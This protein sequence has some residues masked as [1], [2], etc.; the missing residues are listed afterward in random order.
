MKVIARDLAARY[1]VGEVKYPAFFPTVYGRDRPSTEGVVVNVYRI[2]TDRESR[3]IVKKSVGEYLDYGGFVLPESGWRQIDKYGDDDVANEDLVEIQAKMEFP[4]VAPLPSAKPDDA[5]IN[6]E[7]ARSI[8]DKPLFLEIPPSW[9][10]KEVFAFV[11][12]TKGWAWGYGTRAGRSEFIELLVKTVPRSKRVVVFGIHHPAVIPVIVSLG[13]DVVTSGAHGRYA[14]K[15]LYITE[16]SIRP[17]GELKELPCGCKICDGRTPEDLGTKG[18]L[19]AEHNLISFVEEVKKTRNAIVEGRLYEY[20]KRR[21]LTHPQIYKD[22]KKV[23]ASEWITENLPFPKQS[24]IYLFEKE[25]RPEIELGRSLAKKR[26][27]RLEGLAYTYPF[28]QVYPPIVEARPSPELVVRSVIKYQYGVDVNTSQLRWETRKG[29]PRKIYMGDKY[30]GL[31]R[32]GDGFFVPSIEGAKWLKEMAPPPAFRIVLDS[33]GVEA[34]RLKRS[35]LT[36]HVLDVDPDL[37]PNM[38]VIVTD[39]DDEVVAT[40][41]SVL[42]AREVAEIPRT[43]AVK[44]RHR[45][46]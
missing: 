2:W 30:L 27:V 14:D 29:I 8:T 9:T 46:V 21:S 23:V 39:E 43:V 42:T 24:S 33:E 45:A 1:F 4:V 7:V 12:A 35:P 3:K 31:I 20:A 38:E 18:D 17:L 41:R 19:L 5:I 10:E 44:I 37:R 11:E 26:G 22:F 25:C 6:A 16:S 36:D 34:V 32:H 28:G 40:G 15:E 13:V